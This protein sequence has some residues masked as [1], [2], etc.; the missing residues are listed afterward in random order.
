MQALLT[1]AWAAITNLET[2]SSGIY[3]S[4]GIPDSL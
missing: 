4:L 1:S 3:I 2:I